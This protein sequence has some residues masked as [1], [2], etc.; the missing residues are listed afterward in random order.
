[1]I[2]KKL[3]RNRSKEH[4]L[5]NILTCFSCTTTQKETKTDPLTLEN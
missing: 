5:F 2:E 4:V 1:M 3:L